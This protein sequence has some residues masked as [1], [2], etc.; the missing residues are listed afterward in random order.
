MK[1]IVE[2]IIVIIMTNIRTKGNNSKSG[3]VEK[4]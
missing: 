2:A 4:K 1:I 3:N